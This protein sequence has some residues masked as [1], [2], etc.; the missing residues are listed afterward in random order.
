MQPSAVPV[1]ISLSS[2]QAGPRALRGRT[3]TEGR[4]TDT[5]QSREARDVFEPIGVYWQARGGDEWRGA[6]DE[7]AR[8]DVARNREQQYPIQ[9]TDETMPRSDRQKTAKLTHGA[10]ASAD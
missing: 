5:V 9:Y 2:C 1:Y 3:L 6:K 8:R 4:E 7:E 10:P